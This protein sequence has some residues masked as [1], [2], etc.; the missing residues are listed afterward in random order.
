MFHPM[1]HAPSNGCCSI[2]WNE[3]CEWIKWWNGNLGIGLFI[4]P[5]DSGFSHMTQRPTRGA[6][7]GSRL[8]GLNVVPWKFSHQK[9]VEKCVGN[10]A[11]R[12]PNSSI[13]S[14]GIIFHQAGF[15]WNKGDSQSL[16]LFALGGEVARIWLDQLF[17]PSAKPLDHVSN[18]KQPL[19]FHWILVV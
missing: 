3:A 8:I 1:V 13:W 2:H 6:N 4:D 19:T 17:T 18:E 9:R 7:A 16:A 12:S 14:N 10:P 11:S 5:W 15:P